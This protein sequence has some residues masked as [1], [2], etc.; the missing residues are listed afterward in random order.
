M[1]AD[2][3]PTVAARRARLRAWINENFSGS[4]KRFLEDAAARGH[5][6]DGTEVS[7]LQSGKKSFGEVKAAQYEAAAGMPEGYLVSP[8]LFPEMQD[9]SRAVATVS[10]TE[11]SGAY[12][13]VDQI[14]AE[15]QMGAMGRANDDYPEV[16]KAIDFAPA[17]I[18][19][20]VGFV[21]PT[22]RLKLVMGV[23]DS[24]APKIRPGEA[25]LVDTGCNEFVGDGL[26]LIN[27]GYG[28]QIK[29][30]QAAP[31]GIWARSS[32]NIL[33]PPFKLTEESIIG[34]RVYLIHRLERVS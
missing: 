16:I 13:R 4:R 1:A 12:V 17:Y 28:Q 24:M 23:G 27:T 11:T 3:T 30:L 31:D 19:S 8:L 29:A 5:V 22:G 34:G 7:N 25:V 33:Y 9:S 15:A 10:A 32:D 20:V 18:R 6:L 14:D 2:D 26:Y 21:P